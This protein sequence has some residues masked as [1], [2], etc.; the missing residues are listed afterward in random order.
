MEQQEEQEKNDPLETLAAI[1]I[2]IVVVIGALVAWRASVADDGAGDADYEGLRAATNVAATRS[3]N[4]VNAYESY[5]GYVNYWRNNRLAEL[6]EDEMET[7]SPEQL[8]VLTEQYQV[9]V[10]LADAGSY[11]VERRFLERDGSYNVQRQLGEMWADASRE[12]DLEY[13]SKFDEA[14]RGRGK[15]RRLLVAFMILSIAPIFYSLV[16]SVSGNARYTLLGVGSLF[17]VVGALV[18]LLVEMGVI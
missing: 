16:E 13:T 5:G 1:L 7:A 3:L 6:I 2:A 11:L 14:D 9:A 12:K 10:D 4:Y 17:M 18:A 15:T 8:P